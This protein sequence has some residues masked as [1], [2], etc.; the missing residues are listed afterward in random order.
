MQPLLLS[1]SPYVAPAGRRAPN[2]TATA[3]QEFPLP[4]CGPTMLPSILQT[5]LLQRLS[6]GPFCPVLTLKPL[7]YNY[8]CVDIASPGHSVEEQINENQIV[9]K[10]TAVNPPGFH[11]C[12][13]QDL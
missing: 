13:P 7:E 9:E 6:P 11:E 2:V 12:S 8:L 10:D 3:G 5:L 1:P 4:S